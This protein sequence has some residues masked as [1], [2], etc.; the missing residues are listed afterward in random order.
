MDINTDMDKIDT[1]NSIKIGAD[2]I[3][4]IYLGSVTVERIYL[5]EN[6]I[7]SDVPDTANYTDTDGNI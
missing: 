3:N 5:G 1:T 6:Q 2:N 7:W 4:K